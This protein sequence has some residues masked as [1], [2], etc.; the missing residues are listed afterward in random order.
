MVVMF[1][2]F[3]VSGWVFWDAMGSLVMQQTGAVNLFASKIDAITV[4][5]QIANPAVW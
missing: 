5:N 2:L 3:I 1:M 4:A